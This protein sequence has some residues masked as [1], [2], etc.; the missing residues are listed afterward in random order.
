[1]Y[2]AIIKNSSGDY[3]SG[4]LSSEKQDVVCWM[5]EQKK[6]HQMR[7]KRPVLF[8]KLRTP[9]FTNKK[10]NTMTCD[11]LLNKRI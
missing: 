4:I 6:I 5:Q 3:Q 7:D 10:G 2:S 11:F 8:R 9:I 1:M